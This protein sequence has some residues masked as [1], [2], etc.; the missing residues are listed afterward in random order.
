MLLKD[1]TLGTKIKVFYGGE[2]QGV[3]TISS[4]D[5]DNNRFSIM[6]EGEKIYFGYSESSGW[7]RVSENPLGEGWTFS[8][9]E[10]EYTFRI[11]PDNKEL[12]IQ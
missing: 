5:T 12:T 11:L 8:Q 9:R 1:L 7:R 3:E 2:D 4:V 10:E 6:Y